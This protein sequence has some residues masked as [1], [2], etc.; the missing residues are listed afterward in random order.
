MNPKKIVVGVKGSAASTAALAWAVQEALSTGAEIVAV[1]VLRPTRGNDMSPTVAEVRLRE[2][3][4]LSS[5]IRSRVTSELFG[6]LAASTVD[7]RIVVV[8]GHPAT[9]ILSVADA[10]DADLIVVGNGVHDATGD[11]FLGTVAHELTHRSRRPLIVVPA[12]AHARGIDIVGERLHSE[13]PRQTRSHRAG[14]SGERAHSLPSHRPA[15]DAG[16]RS[17]TPGRPRW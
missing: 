8:E 6:P 17:P 2:F 5:P 3:G 16:V 4:Y 7:H 14:K 11:L 9:A 12:E 10:E 1:H 13:M 15:V